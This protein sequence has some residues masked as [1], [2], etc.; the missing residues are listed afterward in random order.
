MSRF[1]QLKPNAETK[2]LFTTMQWRIPV[3]V[4]MSNWSPQRAVHALVCFGTSSAFFLHPAA[5]ASVLFDT[6]NTL[7]LSSAVAPLDVVPPVETPE[8]DGFNL[9]LKSVD[10]IWIAGASDHFFSI[11]LHT[12]ECLAS[13]RN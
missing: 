5:Y 6:A 11:I 12:C 3:K 2:R 4:V 10:L 13:V 9:I 1:R 7:L 8:I